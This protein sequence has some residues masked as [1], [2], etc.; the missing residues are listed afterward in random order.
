MKF[1]ALNKFFTL[2]AL[3]AMVCVSG[4]VPSLYNKFSSMSRQEIENAVV[5]GRTTKSDVLRIF[6][7]PDKKQFLQS[8]APSL[9]GLTMNNPQFAKMQKRIERMERG[10]QG[11]DVSVEIWSY[12]DRDATQMPG[13]ALSSTYA[14]NEEVF[15]RRYLRITFDGNGVVMRHEYH[16]KK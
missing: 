1:W 6:G 4:C 16:A 11:K 10:N 12:L 14:V 9:A 2:F 13:G 15:S 5:D 3:V 8:Q 7:E